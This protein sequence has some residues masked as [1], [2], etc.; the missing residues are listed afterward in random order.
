MIITNGSGCCGKD[1]FAN[2]LSK[3]FNTYKYSSIDKVKELA[4]I[5]GWNG[6][7]TE[8]DRKFLSDLKLLTT[9]YNDMPFK[10]LCSIVDDFNCGM[11]DAKLLLI[12][13]R[14]PEEIEKAKLKFKAITVLVKN[15][16]VKHIK[17]NI[18]DKNVFNYKYDYVIDNSGTIKELENKTK[19]FVCWLIK[20]VFND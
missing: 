12:D 4:K 9:Q 1:T 20:E 2:I 17:S 18:A 6:D 8:K 10:D 5:I 11:L 13:I 16:N 14:E 15:D 7:K 19:E 3:Y